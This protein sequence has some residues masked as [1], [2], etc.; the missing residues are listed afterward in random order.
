M[1]HNKIS[2][3]MQLGTLAIL[4]ML[5]VAASSANA[6][7]VIYVDADAAAGG[8]GS[9]WAA[10]FKYLQD[11]LTT[12]SANDEIRIAQGTYVP[13]QNSTNPDGSE[14]RTATFQL[15]NG[16][17][18]YGG[19]AGYGA[20]DPNERDVDAYETI[21]SGDLLGNDIVPASVEDLPS[22][23]TRSDNCYHVLT[24]VKSYEPDPIGFVLD[25]V[26][27]ASGHAVDGAYCGGGM[28]AGD[29]TMKVANCTF[30]DNCA[31]V[32][33]GGMFYDDKEP[34]SVIS[35]CTFIG[36]SAQSGA[37]VYSRTG[38]TPPEPNFVNCLFADNFATDRGGG[39]YVD[40]SY[41]DVKNCVFINNTALA[42]GGGIYNDDAYA[43][44]M[45]CMISGN[46]AGRNGGGICSNQVRTWLTNCTIVGNEAGE[47]GGGLFDAVRWNRCVTNCILWDNRAFDGPQMAISYEVNLIVHSSCFE[48]GLP[49][50]HI[51]RDSTVSW[52]DGNNTDADPMFVDPGHWDL[53]TWVEGDY[54]L[55]W[56]SPCINAG[57]L[58]GDYARQTDIDGEPRVAGGRVDMGADEVGEKQ[59]DF[60][61]DG[62]I[63]FEDFSVF[64]QSWPENVPDDERCV[65]C[66]LYEDE[67]INALDL[68]GLIEDW[69]WEAD[70]YEP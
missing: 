53:D 52:S 64:S 35:G 27:I 39:M 18:V 30:R 29:V 51:E 63:D 25:G 61:R 13:D 36:N 14:D 34:T 23:P 21:L 22:E 15:I 17:A 7:Q 5:F 59:A 62:I 44:I 4:W 45:N 19:Y 46:F 42:E 60:T 38:D 50:I 58:G 37:G 6:E 43:R 40:E 54:H 55:R 47:K 56:N 2:V 12:A 16:L 24:G 20:H 70:W 48:G 8:D 28:D 10:A 57:D 69:L 33:G 68:A 11:A 26:T 67:Q 31:A 65:L 1:S 32:F 9:S 3:S 49:D 41:I 66:D